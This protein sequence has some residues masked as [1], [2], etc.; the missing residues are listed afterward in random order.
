MVAVGVLTIQSLGFYLCPLLS[1][2]S[3]NPSL[4]CARYP[5]LDPF[6]FTPPESKDPVS[7]CL[8][9]GLNCSLGRPITNLQK[10]ILHLNSC[11]SRI[12]FFFHSDQPVSL[13]PLLPANTHRRAWSGLS[14]RLSCY[15]SILS[16]ASSIWLIFLF[17]IISYCP[18][19]FM[20]P[21]FFHGLRG[22][23]LE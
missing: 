21:S 17:S 13:S 8:E 1:V 12:F 16:S 6:W 9:K 22:G 7:C 4:S 10:C 18:C 15:S 3:L 2:Q 20:P 14:S 5:S 11:P 19:T 23:E